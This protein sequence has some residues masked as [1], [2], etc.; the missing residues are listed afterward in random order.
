ML[1][2]WFYIIPRDFSFCYNCILLSKCLYCM[3]DPPLNCTCD[4]SLNWKT[5]LKIENTEFFLMITMLRER[6]NG[7][8]MCNIEKYILNNI[9][10]DTILN[11]FASRNAQGI[12]FVKNWNIIVDGIMGLAIIW[13]KRTCFIFYSLICN[14]DIVLE[15]LYMWLVL[16]SIFSC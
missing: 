7:L 3:S 16:L 8:A 12:F 15:K 1:S 6:L 10:L 5:F 9:D 2:R 4:R 13:G 14:I 11:D